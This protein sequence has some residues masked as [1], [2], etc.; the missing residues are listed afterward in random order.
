MIS[1]RDYIS[2]IGILPND[3]DFELYWSRRAEVAWA[4]CS[5][6]HHHVASEGVN[7]AV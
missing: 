1:R 3:A 4:T 6:M 2:K 5:A 7:L